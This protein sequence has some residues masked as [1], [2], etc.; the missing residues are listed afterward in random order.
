[1]KEKGGG[2]GNG[3]GL[4]RED[5]Q[6]T[7]RTSWSH[8]E[9][10]GS[11]FGARAQAGGVRVSR[12]SPR[13]LSRVLTRLE[14]LW[15]QRRVHQEGTLARRRGWEMNL[16]DASRQIIQLLEIWCWLPG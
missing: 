3:R 8:S 15:P 7:V 14:A 10:A 13:A 1:M 12:P 11:V 5:A 16:R 4:S 2:L 6:Q 9:G